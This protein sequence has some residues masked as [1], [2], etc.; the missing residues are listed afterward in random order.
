VGKL[1][2][3]YLLSLKSIDSPNASEHGEKPCTCVDEALIKTLGT[4]KY[5]F[6][7]MPLTT[8]ELGAVGEHPKA[9]DVGA[10]NRTLNPVA[11]DL[12]TCPVE[13]TRAQINYG[14]LLRR[15][16][17][18]HASMNLPKVYTTH[19]VCYFFPL[20]AEFSSAQPPKKWKQLYHWHSFYPSS[21]GCAI[22]R[23]ELPT[24]TSESSAV[25]WFNK[26]WKL[27]FCS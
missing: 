1:P 14:E 2:L 13:R 20:E 26:L 27:D 3:N 15:L 11:F 12:S 18:L 10:N 24:S 5:Y 6:A 25:V 23:V 16:S 17:F 4:G 19:I 9:A 21:R 22:A 8:K 7:A